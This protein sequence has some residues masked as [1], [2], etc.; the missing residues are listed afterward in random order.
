M[1]HVLPR[2]RRPTTRFVADDLVRFVAVVGMIE[3]EVVGLATVE[4]DE[5]TLPSLL[6]VVDCEAVSWLLLS[7]EMV[8]LRGRSLLVS[9]W[10][11]TSSTHPE[12][13][14][15]V[16]LVRLLLPLLLPPTGTVRVSLLLVE[17]LLGL[18]VTGIG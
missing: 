17:L 4:E 6:V 15:P 1:K 7:L 16:L 12:S 5:V 11:R 13:P 10:G 3:V 2:L 14:P 9:D 18:S 8:R